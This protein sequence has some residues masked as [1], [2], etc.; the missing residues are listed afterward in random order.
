MAVPRLIPSGTRKQVAGC[1][2]GTRNL[3]QLFRLALNK[4][5]EPGIGCVALWH[6]ACN[7]EMRTRSGLLGGIMQSFRGTSLLSL[8]VLLSIGACSSR[9]D[10]AA[11]GEETEALGEIAC[12]EYAGG[13]FAEPAMCFEL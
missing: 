1:S 12:A 10:D 9:P 3:L 13:R 2:T 4:A 6:A 8:G 7:P 5:P 11:I